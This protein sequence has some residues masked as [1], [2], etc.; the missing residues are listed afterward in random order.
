MAS[1]R[2]SQPGA[3][4]ACAWPAVS[5]GTWISPCLCQAMAINPRRLPTPTAAA[6]AVAHFAGTAVGRHGRQKA[7][8]CTPLSIPTPLLHPI[9]LPHAPQLACSR[10]LAPRVPVLFVPHE[11]G[12]DSV[13]PPRCKRQ[14]PPS[15][16]YRTNTQSA[17]F[18][19]RL[20]ILSPSLISPRGAFQFSPLPACCFRLPLHNLSSPWIAS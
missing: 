5:C 18:S 14:A 7:P 20:P 12:S 17:P 2:R 8:S 9:P 11:S 3:L 13:L 19:Q 15:P 4:P 10:L 1:A 6:A 16:P